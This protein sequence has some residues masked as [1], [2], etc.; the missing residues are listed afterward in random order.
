MKITSKL[1]R[2]VS[3]LCMIAVC[4]M[5]FICLAA[6]SGLTTT[7][8]ITNGAIYYIRNANSGHYL[9]AENSLNFNV[10]QYAYH[11][12]PNQAWKITK[13]SNG[14][15]TLENQSPYYKNQGRKMLSVSQTT[16]NADLFYANSSLTTQQGE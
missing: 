11:G 9:D 3:V 1:F 8:T 6:S 4:S 10:I 15:Y 2:F 12:G 13:N 7:T 5:Q 14:Y 16:T